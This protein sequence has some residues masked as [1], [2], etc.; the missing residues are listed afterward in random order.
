MNSK[1]KHKKL[2]AALLGTV[3]LLAAAGVAARQSAM[4]EEARYLPDYAKVDLSVYIE[5]RRELQEADYM[6]LVRQTGL[7]RQAVDFLAG[8]DRLEELVLWQEKYFAEL[9]VECRANTILT[10]EERL[11]PAERSMQTGRSIDDWELIPCL[12]DGDILI[13]FNSH[14]LGWRNGHA[15]L[16]IDA[17]NR[18]VLEASR[19]GSSSKVVSM[20]HWEEY[21]AFVVLRLK[22]TEFG[23]RKAIAEAAE[24]SLD[25]IPYRL[26]AGMGSRLFAVFAG[27][28]EQAMAPAA[29]KG[30]HCAHLAWY[31]YRQM[32]YDLDSD[33]GL[34]VTP[35]DIYES[36]LLE[37][38][39]VFGMSAER[40]GII[41]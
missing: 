12:E 39:Q 35:R 21:P 30:T 31:A 10:W 22:G 38:V 5:E 36:P 25:G 41:K 15:A 1:R 33:G 2:C 11:H 14:T 24:R 26:E 16:V 19:L 28:T 8:Q 18:L 17:Q 3:F 27:E 29:L 7:G 9:L 20:K 6:L 13:T 34:I 40:G 23:E 37:V 32:G 4:E